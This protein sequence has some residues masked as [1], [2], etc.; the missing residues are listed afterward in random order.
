MKASK[1]S[2]A[3]GPDGLAMVMIGADYL[4][5]TYNLSMLTSIV[6][7]TWKMGKIIP[8]PKNGKPLHLGPSYRPITLKEDL[9]L[10]AHQ[11]GFRADHTTTTAL[12]EMTNGNSRRVEQYTI[13]ALDLS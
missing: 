6:P 13:V 10:A 7:D 3:V 8:I 4:A 9:P 11:H 2:T 12:C 1:N 5:K